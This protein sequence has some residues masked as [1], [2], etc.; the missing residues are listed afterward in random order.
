M[1]KSTNALMILVPYDLIFNELKIA[2]YHKY[3]MFFL[4]L[5]DVYSI[6]F[7]FGNGISIQ[8]VS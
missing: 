4:P 1:L 8:E 7:P 5:A 3:H 6:R 2:L